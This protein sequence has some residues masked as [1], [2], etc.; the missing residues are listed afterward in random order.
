VKGIEPSY[1]AWKA[2]ALP[3]SYTRKQSSPSIDSLPDSLP[4]VG[5]PPS[6]IQYRIANR[7]SYPNSRPPTLDANRNAGRKQSQYALKWEV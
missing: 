4:S 6:T 1:S 7:I 2:A 5:K 3:L